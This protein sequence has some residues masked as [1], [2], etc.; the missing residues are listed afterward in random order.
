MEKPQTK[1]E[2][3]VSVFIE[4][5]ENCQWYRT[6]EH[7]AMEAYEHSERT[8]HTVTVTETQKIRY[9]IGKR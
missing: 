5:C 3:K 4:T 9:S 2:S 1:T 7:W 6:G 8:G